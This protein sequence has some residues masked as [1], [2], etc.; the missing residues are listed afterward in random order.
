MGNRGKMV[1]EI[2]RQVARLENRPGLCLYYAHHT[3]AVLRRHGLSAVIQAGSLQWP[4]VR[5]EEDDGRIDTHFA[6]MWTPSAADT[7]VGRLGQPARDARLGRYCGSPGNS[8]L[9]H[10]ASARRPRLVAWCGVRL[11]RL[12]TCGVL[13]PSR[14]TGWFIARIVMPRFML[15]RFSSGCLIRFTC[16]ED[17][18]RIAR[19]RPGRPSSLHPLRVSP[20]AAATRGV[21]MVDFV[22]PLF[23]LGQCVATPG[24]LA[25]LEKAGQ[26]P[27]TFLTGISTATGETFIPATKG[28]TSRHFRTVI[29][30]SASTSRPKESNCG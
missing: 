1:A 9:Y 14:Q 23:S 5:H 4:R 22:R 11:I 3:A 24:A 12:A 7:P 2:E 8:R 29:A 6:Y 30:S 18:E 28:R 26:T 21:K 15:A 16:A 20:A 25:A 13:R 27:P 19:G 10:T 17:D